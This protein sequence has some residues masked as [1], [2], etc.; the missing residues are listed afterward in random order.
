MA[1]LLIFISTLL[2]SA[3]LLFSMQPMFTKMILPLLG[4]SPAVWNTSMV[5]YQGALL[6]GY[7]YAHLSAKWL[8]VRAQSIIHLAII[9]CAFFALPISIPESTN[10]DTSSGPL[11][12]LL[13]ILTINVGLPFFI[14]SST[15]PMLQKWF[16][17]TGH[18]GARDPYFLYA[19]SNVGSLGALIAYPLIVEPNLVLNAQ[20][21]LWKGG[22]IL[23]ALLILICGVTLFS[24]KPEEDAIDT[25]ETEQKSQTINRVRLK[26]VILAFAPSSLLLGV[27][28][29]ISTDIASVPLLWVIPLALYL[30]TF[31][32]AFAKRPP[33][34]QGLIER[35]QPYLILTL[36]ALFLLDSTFSIWTKLGF[37]L[38]AFFVTALLCH[39]LLAEK[40]PKVAELTEFY[41][42]LSIGGI[43]GGVFNA[44]IAPNIFSSI[45]EY[46]LMI[47]I[48]CLL[49]PAKTG[50]SPKPL[51]DYA[52]PLIVFLVL[53]VIE[54]Y[55]AESV[56]NE[57]KSLIKFPI[58][59]IIVASA[60]FLASRPVRLAL[61]TGAIILSALMFWN[62]SGDKLIYRERSF[63]GVHK[64][65]IHSSGF[66]NI[67]SHGNTI[68]GA[69]FL[70]TDLKGEPLTYYN[71]ASPIAEVFKKFP[72]KTGKRRVAIVG[73]GAGTLASYSRE[74]E[75]WTYY[76]IDPEV[77]LIARNPALFSFLSNSKGA[78]DIVIGDARLKLKE[79]PDKEY[80]LI[81][82][83]AFSSD[84][85]P[86]HLLTR[87]A[88]R[89]YTSKLADGGI[90]AFHTSNN[91]LNLQP[92][93]ANLAAS[94]NLFALTQTK[95]PTEEERKRYW[96][97][98]EWSVMGADV[99]DLIFLATEEQDRG[100][101]RA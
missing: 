93:L 47:A 36:A 18:H 37:H 8:G 95:F 13:T 38:A 19:A 90:L 69:E 94:E 20:S 80:D 25:K 50:K 23:L 49:R 28:N 17:K 34:P 22:Y 66:F 82:L 14:V 40:R 3:A 78:F 68:H 46:P 58:A 88:L 91:Y 11:L 61:T 7:L 32:N 53:T 99:K 41:I 92:V 31:V 97:P 26:W 9:I 64:V 101:G 83:D 24:S 65:S 81:V 2:L 55:L 70:Q 12:W 87:E 89:L 59:I 33:I 75:R 21:S 74:G 1:I 44:L 29:Y 71:P 5:F 98:A 73:L 67:L 60:Y 72:V 86:I 100:L 4:G 63:F 48:V 16:S 84:S 85:I 39:G 52:L 43:L 45:I 10:Y 27:T 96:T 30:L 56:T 54:P 51:Y 57:S 62:G 77:S 6:L 79:A 15:A 42:W 76:E 35:V